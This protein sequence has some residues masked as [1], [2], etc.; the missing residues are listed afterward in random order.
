[1]FAINPVAFLLICFCWN[2]V[3]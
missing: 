1:M 2:Y 3:Q